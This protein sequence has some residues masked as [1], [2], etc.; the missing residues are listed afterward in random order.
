MSLI[1]TLLTRVSCGDCLG[2]GY[3]IANAG[4]WSETYAACETCGGFGDAEVCSGCG[5]VPDEKD[6]CNCV[7]CEFCQ[8]PHPADQMVFG[9][10]HSCFDAAYTRYA[11]E[12]GEAAVNG[13]G[14]AL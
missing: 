6:A 13:Y 8:T 2:D 14:G 3:I 5:E 7:P 12:M 9:S 1:S 4:T 11:A 10:C